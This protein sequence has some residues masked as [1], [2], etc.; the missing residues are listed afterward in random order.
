VDTEA[1]FLDKLQSDPSDDTTRLVYAD[2]LEER[3]DPVSLAR[4]EFLR[5]TV[6]LAEPGKRKGSKKAR[7]K[8]LQELA[9]GLDTA[10][11]PVVS[12]LGIENCHKKR[13]EA[14]QGFRWPPVR[15]EFL[16]ERQWEELQPTGDRAVRFC[17]G[18]RQQVHYC[19]TIVEARKQASA[20]HCIALDLGVIRRDGDLQ[21]AS[22]W[23]GRVSVEMMQQE[24]ERLRP[25]PVS[26][27][28][29]RRKREA[30]E[31]ADSGA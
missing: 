16:C 19:D 7:R 22:A 30:K 4:A 15:F 24:R 11:L 18:C 10:W 31:A 17:D 3:G 20:G 21:P 5:L 8:R 6:Q 29:E 28:R 14:G 1:G 9:A 13:E 27:E 26:A 25:D 2:W 12:R 23:V